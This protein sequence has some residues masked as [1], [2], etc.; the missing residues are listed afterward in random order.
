VG[1]LEELK[2]REKKQ[3]I[4]STKVCGQFAIF[5]GVYIIVHN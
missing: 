1:F 3:K 2:G 4:N 5:L